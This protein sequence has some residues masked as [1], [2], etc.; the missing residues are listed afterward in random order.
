MLKNEGGGSCLDKYRSQSFLEHF[1][2][3]EP[4]F[5]R[6]VCESACAYLWVYIYI[7]I[8]VYIQ[9]RRG[10]RLSRVTTPPRHLK[11]TK[12]SKFGKFRAHERKFQGVVK[13][14]VC[15]CV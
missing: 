4:E 11:I 12:G 1:S 13:F 6:R 5:Q 2:G 15:V 7:Y 8:Y 9:A 14:K 10:T 3:I